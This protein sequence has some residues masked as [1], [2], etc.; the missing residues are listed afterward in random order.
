MC[1]K[2]DKELSEGLSRLEK[3]LR[4][5]IL[6]SKEFKELK[7]KIEEKG[8]EMQVL[9][10]IMAREGIKEELEKGKKMVFKLTA[11]DKEFLK[12]HGIKW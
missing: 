7:K 3:L 11:K 6:N 10:M 9:L 12:K 2:E 4:K 1:N 8:L 5:T